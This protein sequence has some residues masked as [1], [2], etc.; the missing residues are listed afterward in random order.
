MPMALIVI[1]W[2]IISEFLKYFYC[3]YRQ[4]ISID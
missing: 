1:V 2:V 3:E 4:D